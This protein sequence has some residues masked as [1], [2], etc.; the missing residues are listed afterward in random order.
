M[1]KMAMFVWLCGIFVISLVVNS[2]VPF[3][4]STQISDSNVTD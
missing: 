4:F 3:H 2:L 1:T